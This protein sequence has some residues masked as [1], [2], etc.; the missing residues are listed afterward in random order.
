MV[1]PLGIFILFMRKK[2]IDN[3]AKVNKKTKFVFTY[4]S[5][6]NRTRSS[7]PE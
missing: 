3:L 7:L 4:I 1:G 5:F 6:E 2:L